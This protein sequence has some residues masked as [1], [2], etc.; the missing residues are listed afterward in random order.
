[1]PDETTIT[2]PTRL[3]DRLLELASARGLTVAQVVQRLVDGAPSRPKPT[4]GGYRS[5]GP[6]AAE[7]IDRELADRTRF[8]LP[9][10][11]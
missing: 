1:M 10:D 3:Y 8:G 2:V 6:L 7:E 11:G 9:S 4:M 5:G